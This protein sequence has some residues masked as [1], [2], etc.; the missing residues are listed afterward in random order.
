MNVYVLIIDHDH[1][2]DVNVYATDELAK[3]ALYEYVQEWWGD[4]SANAG[5]P[6]DCPDN[7][8]EAIAMYFEDNSEWYA[9]HERP[10]TG[11]QP[12]ETWYIISTDDQSVLGGPYE[13]EEEAVSD[14]D[15]ARGNGVD[16]FVKGIHM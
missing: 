16:C 9:I 12:P 6:K 13:S 7:A 1:G 15:D 10:I 4:V 5:Y 2:T 11:L 3:E 8:A 14:A